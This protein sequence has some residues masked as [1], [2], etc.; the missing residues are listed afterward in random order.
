[1]NCRCV[2]RALLSPMRRDGLGLFVVEPRQLGACLAFGTE[3]FVELGVDRVLAPRRGCRG[4]SARW[5]IRVMTQ[6]CHR[7]EGVPVEAARVADQPRRDVD[8]DNHERSR[9][10]GEHPQPGQDGA[11]E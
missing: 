11:M 8:G 4:C 5:M 7:G 3:Q 10:D 9:M 1:M 6:V 2:I